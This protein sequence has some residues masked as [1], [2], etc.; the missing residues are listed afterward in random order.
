VKLAVYDL[1]GRL[2]RTLVDREFEPGSWS[3]TWDGSDDRGRAM[4]S[5]LYLYR[6]ET[7]NR[8]LSRKMML[9]K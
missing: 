8:V 1:A 2:V 6:L 4:P 7:A 9:V 5:G 3:A